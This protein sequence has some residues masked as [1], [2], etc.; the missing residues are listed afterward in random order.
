[1]LGRDFDRV[2][3][4]SPEAARDLLRVLT[5]RLRDADRIRIELTTLDTPGRVA[6]RLLE[7]AARFGE[8]TPSGV[9]VELP[10][11]Q[12]ELAAW[13][14]SSREATVKAL[15]VFR[16]AGWLTTKRLEVTILDATLLRRRASLS[17]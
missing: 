17:T 10:L 15:R 12:D 8:L 13:C 6:S 2:L 5:A 9:R 3:T 1:V 14:G 4:D 16:E 11:T 7:L